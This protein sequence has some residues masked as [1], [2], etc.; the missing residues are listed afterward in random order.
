MHDVL[1]QALVAKETISY[2]LEFDTKE[3]CTRCLFLNMSTKREKDILI[4]RGKFYSYCFLNS[5]K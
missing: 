2:E 4:I 5:K 1:Q 3:R